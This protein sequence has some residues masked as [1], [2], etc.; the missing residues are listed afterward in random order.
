[1]DRCKVCGTTARYIMENGDV[2]C[3]A[4][5]PDQLASPPTGCKVFSAT[6]RDD[7][8]RLGERVTEWVHAN[9]ITVTDTFIT[10]SSDNAYHCISLVV[11]FRD[12]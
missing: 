2:Y 9:H 5:A 12:R 11:F 10:Q 8:E 3:T 6:R 4:H 1:M 7:R